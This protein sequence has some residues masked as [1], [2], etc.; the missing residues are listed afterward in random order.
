MDG[1]REFLTLHYRVASR[2]DTQYWKDASKR[3]VPDGLAE[4][5]ERWQAHLPDTENIF[6]YYH[7]LPPYSYMCILLGMG[8]IP[9]ASSPAVALSDDTAAQKEFADIRGRARHLVEKLPNQY[10]YFAQLRRNGTR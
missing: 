5:I 7:G 4:R 2:S 6:P 9:L 8:G 1:V 10:E 3:P